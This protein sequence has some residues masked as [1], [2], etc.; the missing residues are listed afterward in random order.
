MK[1]LEAIRIARILKASYASSPKKTHRDN[2]HFM[3]VD[4]YERLVKQESKNNER[5]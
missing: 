1:L 4:K 2:R 5:N 3:Y